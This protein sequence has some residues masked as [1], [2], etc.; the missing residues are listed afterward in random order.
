MNA[1]E[2]YQERYSIYKDVFEGRIPKRI[3]IDVC[4]V[5]SEFVI[6]Y[7][8]MDLL[9]AQYNTEMIEDAFEKFV[10]EFNDSDIF[11]CY[12]SRSAWGNKLLESQSFVMGSSGVIQHPEV[13]GL[14][15]EDYDYLIESPYDC[16]VEKVLPNQYKALSRSPMETATAFAKYIVYYNESMGSI[17][18]KVSELTKEYGFFEYE[19]LGVAEAPFD[20]LADQLRGFKNINMDTRRIPEKVEASCEAL[21][22]IMVKWALAYGIGEMGKVDLPLH[23]GPYMSPKDFQRFYFPT[24]KKL[25]AEISKAG[26]KVALFMENEW[27]QHY[28]ILQELTEGT[29]LRFEYG[30]PKEIKERFGKRFIISGLYPI[31]L[32]KTG[33]KEQCIDKAKEL[34]DI[35]APGG[36][37]I[38]NFD[39]DIISLNSVNP[40]NL[41]VF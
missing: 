3:P 37:Y 11:P 19:P 18:N 9:Q 31:S 26:Q 12:H 15:P 16:L 1:N 6:E 8:G 24:F 32:L 40:D 39:K 35:L 21:L 34:L 14:Y 36:N 33:T 41:K 22:P 2:L 29:M 20:F 30:D 4:S 28:D 27:T 17:Y 5:A 13:T 10:K 25:V 23:L 7:V 38:F